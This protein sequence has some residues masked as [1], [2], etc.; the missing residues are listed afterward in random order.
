MP[1]ALQIRSGTGGAADR[2]HS[3]GMF[4]PCNRMESTIVVSNSPKLFCLLPAL[5]NSSGAG[6]GRSGVESSGEARM[7]AHRSNSSGRRT[8]PPLPASGRLEIV[9]PRRC[10]FRSSCK[11]KQYPRGP[12]PDFF[13][14]PASPIRTPLDCL[15]ASRL[16]RSVPAAEGVGMQTS[17]SVITGRAD[18]YRWI[19][20]QIW[21]RISPRLLKAQTREDVIGSYEGAD[22]GG[23]ALQFVQLADLILQVLKERKF[24]KQSRKAHINFLADSIGA[25]GLVTPRSSR[26]ICERERARIERLHHIVRYEFWIKCSCGYQ[27]R[28]L[29]HACPK[30]EAEI[31]LRADLSLDPVF[32]W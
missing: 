17:F 8:S 26:D 2:I 20:N 7:R 28:S 31:P 22:I 13:L 11:P 21:D 29:R 23:Y 27:G 16:P 24:P 4:G 14:H 12:T 18:N 30:C 6:Q 10:S 19:L 5:P 1:P 9:G 15:A 25:H 3:P 32:P